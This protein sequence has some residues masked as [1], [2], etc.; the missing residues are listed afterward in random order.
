MESEDEG[1]TTQAGTYSY[2]IE[3]LDEQ[4]EHC[5]MEDA[6]ASFEEGELDQMIRIEKEKDLY[7]KFP[8]MKV[9]TDA[10]IQKEIDYAIQKEKEQQPKVDYRAKYALMKV[11][12]DNKD[13]ASLLRTIADLKAEVLSLKADIVLL[14][15]DMFQLKA[16]AENANNIGRSLWAWMCSCQEYRAIASKP[17]WDVDKKKWTRKPLG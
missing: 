7:E 8:G 1:S 17:I 4:L 9:M 16:T 5:K 11:K 6:Y 12:D 2:P 15:G 14:K 10:A 13:W 3:I